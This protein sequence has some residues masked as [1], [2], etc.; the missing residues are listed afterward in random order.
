[1]GEDLG[2][3]SYFEAIYL[4]R[5]TKLNVMVVEYPNYGINDSAHVAS[6][7]RILE[8]AKAVREFATETLSYADRDVMLFGRSMGTSVAAQMCSSS[9]AMLVLA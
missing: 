6:A 3:M 7:K 2:N 8:Q 1:M 9:N 5:H 4:R